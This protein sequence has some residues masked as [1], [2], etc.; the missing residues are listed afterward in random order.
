MKFADYFAQAFLS[1]STSMFPTKMFKE[2]PV[3]KIDILMPQILDA[4]YKTSMDEIAQNPIEVLGGFCFCGVLML[5]MLMGQAHQ[6]Q[7]CLQGLKLQFL[8]DL[9]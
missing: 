4:I 1:M 3:L 6:C 2:S 8:W 5:S 7:S 9:Q